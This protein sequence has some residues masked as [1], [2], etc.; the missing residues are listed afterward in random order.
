M[1]FTVFLI[2]FFGIAAIIPAT[3]A[4]IG[5]IRG[6]KQFWPCV[7]GTGWALVLL[8]ITG[9]GAATNWGGCPVESGTTS[10]DAVKC[11]KGDDETGCKPDLWKV[12]CRQSLLSV[13]AGIPARAYCPAGTRAV[14]PFCEPIGFG[15][16]V[17]QP[18]ATWSDLSFVA[19]GLWILWLFQYFGR[20]GYGKFTRFFSSGANPM[21]V[22]GPLSIAYGMIVIFMGPPSQWFHAS[23]KEWAGWFDTM[24]VVFW[25]MFNAIY[26]WYM[27]GA[28][29]WGRARDRERTIFILV[30][31]TI[32]MVTFGM[33]GWVNSG[34][35][36]IFYF[37][38]GGLWGLGEI[39]YVIWTACKKAN[40]KYRRTWWLFVSNLALL[41]TT[42]TIWVFW[43]DNIIPATWCQSHESFPGH[44]LFHILASFSTILTF[45]S[46]ASERSMP[47][48]TK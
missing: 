14:Y 41:A 12:E 18:W 26:V 15:D 1:G 6:N 8:L 48:R 35:R 23:I 34:A 47:A 30:V 5:L 40:V 11:F 45:F 36:L 33:I 22:I 13:C 28:A 38:S 10:K 4:I 32:L 21:V 9:I 24:S 2:V 3:W 27:I 37:I 44:A 31:W 19:A 16:S 7:V 46:F 25:L 17:K 42:M 43:N 29:M 39:V 20:F